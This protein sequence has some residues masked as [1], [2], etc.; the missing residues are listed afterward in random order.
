MDLGRIKG[1]A[2]GE[3]LSWYELRR[4]CDRVRR[5]V[6]DVAASY[7]GQLDPIRPTFGVL[8][9]EWYPAEMVHALLDRLIAG[10]SPEELSAMALDAADHIMQRTLRGV[11]RTLFQF[12]ATP[13]RHLRY[14][15]RLWSMHYDNGSIV[16]RKNSETSHSFTY[17]SWTSHHPFICSMNMAASRPIYSLMGCQDV[18]HE[19]IRC[20]SSG[21]AN[22]ENIVSWRR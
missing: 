18:M 22:C 8:A 20:V 5:A 9:S 2:F 6:I 4:D 10:H 21:A 14:A 12:L 3:F 17:V 13:N 15:G 11:Y 16:T 7:P 1:V 19:R